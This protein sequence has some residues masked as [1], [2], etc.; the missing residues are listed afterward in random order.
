MLKRLAIV[1]VILVAAFCSWWFNRANLIIRGETPV[2]DIMWGS[3][4]EHEHQIVTL[5]KGEEF[6]VYACIDD[7]SYYGYEIRLPSGRTGYVLKGDTEI[8]QKSFVFPSYSQPIVW[9]CF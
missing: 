6:A 7:K 1:A 9:N 2:F 5:H 3:G 8:T 4:P